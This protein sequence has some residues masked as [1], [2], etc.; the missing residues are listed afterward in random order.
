MGVP[1]LFRSSKHSS[2]LFQPARDMQGLVRQDRAGIREPGVARSC[3]SK[4]G[5]PSFPS[6]D[7]PL[8]ADHAGCG[9][10]IL[11]SSRTF[12]N[13]KLISGS[14]KF[15]ICRSLRMHRGLCPI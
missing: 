14:G 15:K 1:A 11:G 5:T 6:A 2:H 4:V 12:P 13:F 8:P 9:R 7:P 10:K 3:E